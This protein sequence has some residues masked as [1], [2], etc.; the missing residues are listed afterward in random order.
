MTTYEIAVELIRQGFSV[1]PLKQD[2]KPYTENGFKDAVSN[3]AD[4][5]AIWRDDALI[6]VYT[7][8][9][10]IIVL[11]L[12]MKVS[13]N[14]DVLVDGF[15]SLDEAWLDV[16][17]TFAYDSRNGLGR[18]LV[19]RAPEGM[20]LPRQMGYR[21]M[22][23]V[24]RCSGQG[25]VAWMGGV[26]QP[27]EMA[28]APEWLLDEK[29]AR[30]EHNYSGTVADWFS[31]LTPG[32]P[33]AL[34]RRA[35]EKAAQRFEDLGNDFSHSDLI[36]LQFEA[37]RLGAEGN[38]GIPQYLEFLE[39]LFLS[40]TGAH[41]RSEEDWPHEWQ[42]GLLSGLEKYGDAIDLLKSLPDYS[43]GLVPKGI[44][45]SLV[46]TP[47]G[48]AEFS[49]LLGE[50][51]KE[52][53][54][55]NR[56]LSIL[57]SAPATRDL[58]RDWGLQFVYK[59]VQDARVRPE[60][61]RENPR[62]EEKR[63]AESEGKDTDLNLLTDEE[64]NYL[65]TR[66]TFVDH[67]EEVARQFGW[68]QFAYFRA[69][70]WASAALTYSFKG[71]IPMKGTQKLN[72][73][74]W[75]ITMGYSGSGK[76][77]ALDFRNE[78]LRTLFSGDSEEIPS[79]DLGTDSSPQ[80]LHLALLERDGHPSFFGTDE[81]SGFFKTL[82]KREWDS[83]LEDTLSMYY[84]GFVPPSNKLNLKEM[85]GKSARTAFTQQ[86]FATP[87]RLTETLSRD[88]FKSGFLARYVWSFGHK[89]LDSDDRFELSQ[90]DELEVFDE[91]PEEVRK[92]AADLI[93]SASRI[94]R[95]NP[96]ALKGTPEVLKRLSTA[97]RDMFRKSESR[98][99]WDIVEPSVTRLMESMLKA[100][101]ICAMYRGDSTILMDDALHAIKA[102]EEWLEN[103]HRVVAMISA[104]DWQR[105]CDEIEDWVRQ[106]GGSASK[107][108]ILNRFR[109]SIA[110]DGREIDNYLN[111]LT[112]SGI[113]NRM[114]AGGGAI[115]FEIN[116][117]E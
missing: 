108:Q 103:L 45:D 79:Y 15:T 19:Y 93:T 63:A 56:I 22:K 44:P 71:F 37:I 83:G 27:G 11:D 26:P 72:L 6:G 69:V 38:S 110:K 58:A 90:S 48:K 59:R 2:G 106:R 68:T 102:A 12:D 34:V 100:A 89:P 105:L 98:Q 53:E 57:W 74:L 23:G 99:H 76:T 39:D 61:T 75:M 88:Q 104:G 36:E 42:E 101:G 49:K 112:E 35:W 28:E 10:G 80:G 109:N 117:S 96:V 62:I 111:F 113:L 114:E 84:T 5:K 64:R 24:D 91:S 87:D 65:K 54:D 16:P 60:P 30:Q 51:V 41:S 46:T 116:G 52:T 94:E 82:G 20:N 8:A 115:K 86:M 1:F 50:L 21:G 3:E 81:A 9:S 78:I 55:D 97:Y 43:I 67:V 85:K 18:H 33:N 4:L 70:A 25:Y 14:G 17:E 47:G 92:I 66:P 95:G 32:E 7:G 77:T 107:A 40:R 31:G 29:E 13:D 73:N